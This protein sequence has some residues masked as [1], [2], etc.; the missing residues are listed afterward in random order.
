MTGKALSSRESNRRNATP[1]SDEATADRQTPDATQSTPNSDNLLNL[2]PT[3]STN[4][5]EDDAFFEGL[6]VLVQDVTDKLSRLL[7]L[8]AESIAVGDM[9][10]NPPADE[11]ITAVAEADPGLQT[12]LLFLLPA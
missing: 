6:P 9:P 7:D 3:S 11:G 5:I 12:V 1:L 4:T 8:E 2:D 10:F